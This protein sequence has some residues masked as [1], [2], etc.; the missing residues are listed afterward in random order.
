MEE[1]Q[2]R[3]L[4]SQTNIRL[5]V[6]NY[7]I[8][9]LFSQK[10]VLLTPGEEVFIPSNIDLK[11][12]PHYVLCEIKEIQ[13]VVMRGKLIV[14]PYTVTK[15]GIVQ[16]ALTNKSAESSYVIRKDELLAVLTFQNIG[17]NYPLHNST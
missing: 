8:F 13:T 3:E 14:R 15:P 4:I 5:Q 1:V 17:K 7:N 11:N 16:L 10:Q 6:E 9:S 12:I 2:I